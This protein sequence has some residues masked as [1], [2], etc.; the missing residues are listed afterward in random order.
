MA[1]YNDHYLKEPFQ[2]DYHFPNPQMADDGFG[3]LIMIGGSHLTADI[4]WSAFAWL[5]DCCYVEEHGHII[6]AYLDSRSMG[7]V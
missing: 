6:G 5:F 7:H 1:I 3:N 4:W 2:M